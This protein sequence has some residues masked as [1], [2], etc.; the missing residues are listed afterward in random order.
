M[1]DLHGAAIVRINP[2]EATL[3]GS[4]GVALACG[5]LDVLTRIDAVM[6]RS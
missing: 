5:A 6:P 2:A 1:H 4:K 3:N